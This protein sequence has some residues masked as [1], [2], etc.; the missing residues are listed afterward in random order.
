MQSKADGW[1]SVSFPVFKVA[2]VG[3]KAGLVP[4]KTL[5]TASDEM[6][7]ATVLDLMTAQLGVPSKHAPSVP[8]DYPTDYAD[9]K[10]Y[11]PAWQEAI[12]GVPAADAIRVACEF[13][14]NAEKTRGKSMIFLGGRHQPL[15]SQRHDLPHHH[16]P[17]HPCAAV[18][19]FNGGGWAA[20]C[21]PGKGASPGGLVPRWPSAWTG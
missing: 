1:R 16:Q 7:V 3:T 13:A 8:S 14:D 2:G 15:V 11:T 5:A 4:F 9:P 21:R 18:R 12:T 10:P 6:R 19:G 17:D 20:L